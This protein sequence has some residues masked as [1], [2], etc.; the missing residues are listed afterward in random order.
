ML[1][2]STWEFNDK[3]LAFVSFAAFD[4]YM[5]ERKVI[6]PKNMVA[7]HIIIIVAV[8]CSLSTTTTQATELLIND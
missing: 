1:D 8:V 5:N 7:T 6:I 2:M 4:N 3:V